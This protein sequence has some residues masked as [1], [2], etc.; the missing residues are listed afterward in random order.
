MAVL[1]AQVR[2]RTRS[3]SGLI[4]AD[5]SKS[6]SPSFTMMGFA[7]KMMGSWWRK[8]TAPACMSGIRQRPRSRILVAQ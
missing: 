7:P 3:S 5:G 2:F 8:V 4:A 6:F 1:A